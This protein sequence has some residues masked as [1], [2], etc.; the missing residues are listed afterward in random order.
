MARMMVRFPEGNH[1]EEMVTLRVDRDMLTTIYYALGEYKRNLLNT[2]GAGEGQG[3]SFFHE[4][5]VEDE[6]FCYNVAG[7]CATGE[8]LIRWDQRL[9]AEE[10]LDDLI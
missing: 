5:D 2:A 3:H 9:K 7:V 8:Y 4:R 10:F 6:L 1:E